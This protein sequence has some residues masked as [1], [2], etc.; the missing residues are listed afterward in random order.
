MKLKL[1]CIFLISLWL[2]NCQKEETETKLSFYYWK[3]RFSV[4][5]FEM[6]FLK[7]NQVKKL[8]VRYFDIDLNDTGF[9]V[10]VGPISFEKDYEHF[11]I[12]PVVYIKNRVFTSN[13]TSI[14]SL[15]DKTIEFINQINRFHKL[16]CTELQFDCDWTKE[17]SQKYFQFLEMVKKETNL[18][19]SATIRLHQI[20]YY[21]TTGVPPVDYGVLMYYNMGKISA[22]SSNSI[23]QR[24]T[25]DKYIRYLSSYP[26]RL[27][28]ALPIFG[29]GIH[30]RHQ[31]VE[32]LINKMNF[33]AFI[34]DT[35]FILKNQ[36]RL[37]AKRNY[38]KFGYYFMK[39][40]EIKMERISHN[41]I[42]EMSED[43]NKNLR[44]KPGEIIIYD[45]D[46]INLN[47]F[48]NEGKNFKKILDYF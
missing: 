31:Q 23:Y 29:W 40:D 7:S 12:V 18:T 38:I 39:G 46:S 37:I 11:T 9:A 6:E 10:P 3:T 4:S 33:N 43:L 48:K 41:D 36:A 26:L 27:N 2:T 28:V 45:L 17:S 19:I 8:Y 30:I 15:S 16:Q 35:N 24:E 47:Q 13:K 32:G 5:K 14:K 21:K 22:D 42:I 25:A 1:F 44:K 34:G 20:K